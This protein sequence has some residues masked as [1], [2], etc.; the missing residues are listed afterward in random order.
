[1]KEKMFNQASAHAF[2]NRAAIQGMGDAS[3][4]SRSLYNVHPESIN[5]LGQNYPNPFS[6]KSQIAFSL[7]QDCVVSL[8]VYDILGGEVA[9]LLDE[10][11]PA[12]EYVIELDAQEF[13]QGVYVYTIIAGEFT[14]SKKFIVIV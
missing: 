9:V 5:W 6:H 10:R 2:Q 4:A 11:R 8:K 14:E 1:M 13:R 3:H 7:A 12:G